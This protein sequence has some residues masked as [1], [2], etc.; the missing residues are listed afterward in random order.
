MRIEGFSEARRG[1]AVWFLLVAVVCGLGAAWLAVRSV[2]AARREVPVVM[3]RREVAPLT[4]LRPGDVMVADVPAAALPPGAL[5]A[6]RA[7][8]GHFTRMGLVPGEIVTASALNGG[9]TAASAFDVR[10]AGL[11]ETQRCGGQASNPPSPA[12]SAAGAPSAG[13]GCRPLVAMSLPISA[14]QGFEMVHTGDSVD[15]VAGYGVHAGTV[16]QIVASDVPVLEKVA[17]GQGG[18]PGV[19]PAS[20]ATSGYLVVG[21]S[22]EQ[23]LRLQLVLTEG[24]PAVLLEPPGAP[25]QPAS[26]ST[27]ILD[28]SGLAGTGGAAPGV[29]STAG[30]LPGAG[31]G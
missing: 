22:P 31:E 10:L 30:V 9:V 26:L 27:R 7:A 18:V 21:V 23:A 3:A 8:A 2:A 12:A 4:R 5:R 24:K 16:A 6:V 11:A 20:G 17:S 14:D 28:T 25:P 13:G 1:G 19:A 29:P 15:V